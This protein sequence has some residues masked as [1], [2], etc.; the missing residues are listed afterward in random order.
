[1][2]ESQ[3]SKIYRSLRRQIDVL[4]VSARTGSS[5][6]QRPITIGLRA[7]RERADLG[8][9]LLSSK[10]DVDRPVGGRAGGRVYRSYRCES[11]VR[12]TRAAD[13][14]VGRGNGTSAR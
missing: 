4:L 6:H 12:S 2:C 5:L 10:Q 11:S 7:L 1:M 3:A 13:R 14:R 9:A 8:G